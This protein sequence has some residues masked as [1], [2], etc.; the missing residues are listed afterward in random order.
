MSD[1][2][3][4]LKQL[5]FSKN[6]AVVY[7]EKDLTLLISKWLL[8]GR[9]RKLGLEYQVIPGVLGYRAEAKGM[10]HRHFGE[11]SVRNSNAL[12]SW[13]EDMLN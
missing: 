5:N 3:S 8:T 10:S 7:Y 9:T 2:E 6:K 4:W 12:K 13:Y 1:A 11:V